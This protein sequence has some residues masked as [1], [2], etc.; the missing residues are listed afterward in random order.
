MIMNLLVP[1]NDLLEGAVISVIR[2]EAT[3]EY[4]GPKGISATVSTVRI[5]L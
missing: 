5:L 1:L 3:A 4:E 2:R